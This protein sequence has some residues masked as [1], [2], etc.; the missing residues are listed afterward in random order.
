VIRDRSEAGEKLAAR[1][2]HY[3]DAKPVVLALPRG[4]VPVGFEIAVALNAPLDLLFVR[5]IGVPWQPELAAAAVAEVGGPEMVRNEQV[6]RLADVPEEYLTEQ[7]AREL[8]E[9]TR[10]RSLYRGGKPVIDVAG[11]TAI[12]VDDGIATGATVRAAL[13][14]LRRAQPARIVL[15]VPVAPEETIKELANEADEICCLETPANFG[16][17]S[18]FYKSFRQTSDEEVIDLLRRAAAAQ[19]SGGT[20]DPSPR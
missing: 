13:R 12:V 11:R 10:R 4:G 16:A 6:I 15:A 17:I 8:D 7:A 5:K 18:Q 9:I 3:R 20:P 1:L 14:A 2:Q 19:P